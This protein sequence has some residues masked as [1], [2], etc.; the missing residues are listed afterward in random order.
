M[1]YIENHLGLGKIA[2]ETE[3]D[4]R[5][6]E[7]WRDGKT[8]KP[9]KGKIK[10]F[11]KACKISVADFKKPFPEF[12]IIFD[13][14]NGIEHETA[15]LREGILSYTRGTLAPKAVKAYF[16]E[17]SLKGYWL[18]CHRW[19]DFQDGDPEN[20]RL[21]IKPVILRH[22]LK[23]YAYDALTNTLKF[24]ITTRKAYQDTGEPWNYEG[25]I[26]PLEHEIFFTFEFI[27]GPHH[28]IAT[29]LTAKPGSG[30]YT[31]LAGLM[32]GGSS[33]KDLEEIRPT[34]SRVI[35]VKVK[36]PVEEKGAL[37]KSRRFPGS[38]IRCRNFAG[39]RE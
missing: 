9:Q 17:D 22:V 25:W 33:R 29:V 5:T 23:V 16:R 26:I 18:L 24:K 21:K 2:E 4:V 3:I 19:L 10:A 37:E 39:Y 7:K 12:R 14:A 34:A 6:F 32:L 1:E 27:A 35:L 38:G 20:P 13:R 30:S 31:Q 8:D 28:E 36:E 11:C 15:H